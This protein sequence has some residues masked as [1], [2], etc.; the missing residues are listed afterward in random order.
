MTALEAALSYLQ[1]GWS[2]IP[3]GHDKR[4][5]IKWQTFQK[6]KPSEQQVRSWYEQWP[7]AGVAIITGRISG[8][9]VLDIDPRHGGDKT[10]LHWLDNGLKLPECPAVK[11]GGGGT[12]FYLKHPGSDVPTVPSVAPGIDLKAEGAYVIAPPSLHPSGQRYLFFPGQSPEEIPLPLCAL[13]VSQKT[14]DPLIMQG[15]E[16]VSLA[17]QGVSEGSRD[18]TCTRLAGYFRNLLPA[19]VTLSIL[20]MWAERCQPT[21]ELEVAQKCVK[22]VYRYNHNENDISSSDNRVKGLLL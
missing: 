6:V 13:P 5:L 21:L 18:Q 20:V 16:W 8:L 10:L 22:S 9:I 14:Q 2:I 15:H 1:H 11:T 19:D 7:D 4:P 3:V 17:L 12:H